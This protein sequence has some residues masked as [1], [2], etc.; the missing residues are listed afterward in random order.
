MSPS[1]AHFSC[2]VHVG[3]CVVSDAGLPLKCTDLVNAET[4]CLVCSK[5]PK[6]SGAIHWEGAPSR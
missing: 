2:G 4:A 1:N 6:D 5:Q 3:W